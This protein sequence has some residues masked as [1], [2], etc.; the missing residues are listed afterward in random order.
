MTSEQT[1]EPGLARVP[2]AEHLC[3]DTVLS[4]HEEL[5]RYR[6]RIG[7]LEK[8][9]NMLATAAEEERK[10]ANRYQTRASKA[11]IAERQARAL[12]EMQDEDHN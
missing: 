8:E 4:L 12:L 3:L 5:A 9:R 10:R 2:D 1:P 7:E 6:E 11:E